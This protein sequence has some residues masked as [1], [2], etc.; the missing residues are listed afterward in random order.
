MNYKRV[1][2]KYDK[3]NKRYRFFYEAEYYD[4]N[5]ALHVC[6]GNFI[7]IYLVNNYFVAIR[8]GT[9]PVFCCETF[10]ELVFWIKETTSCFPELIEG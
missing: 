7:D 4:H 9:T 6:G 5:K 8:Y 2:Y 1:T 3:K 10:D